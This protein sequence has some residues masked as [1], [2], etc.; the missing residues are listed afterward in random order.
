[1]E[2]PKSVHNFKQEGSK[3][4]KVTVASGIAIGVV[5]LLFVLWGFFFLKNVASGSQK[6]QVGGIQDQFNFQNVQQAQQQL[7][8]D[9]SNQNT[10][11][12]QDTQD[13]SATG[14]AQ[15][16]NTP[17]QVGQQGTDQFGTPVSQ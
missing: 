6:L 7:Q 13:Q 4:D 12:A 9:L 11:N 3:E 14:P 5:I 15:M 16:Q 8:K 1:M 2:L 10:V 17:M